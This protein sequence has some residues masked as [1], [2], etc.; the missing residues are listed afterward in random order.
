M[1]FENRVVV[2]TGGE[3]TWGGGDETIQVG[4]FD[5][6]LRV[7]QGQP[8]SLDVNSHRILARGWLRSLGAGCSGERPAALAGG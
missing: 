6:H 5:L 7:P 3:F 8:A 2:V 4:G 1:R